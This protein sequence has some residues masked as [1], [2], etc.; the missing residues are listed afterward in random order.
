MKINKENS[1]IPSPN[2]FPVVG[3]GASAG[4]LEAF[5]KLLKAIPENSGMAYVLVQHLDPTHESLLPVLL[6]KVTSLPVLE[7]TDDLKVQPDHIYIIPSNKMLLANDGILKLSPRPEKG[8]NQRNLPIDL[9]FNSLAE[10]HQSYAIGVVLSGTATDGTLGLKAIK[11]QGGLTFAQDE[12][13]AAY[14]SMPHSAMM[15][16]VV[17][18]ILPPEKIPGKLVELT[19][20]IYKIGEQPQT[21]LEKDEAAF[22][23]I[24]SLLRIRKGTDFK[25]GRA[26]CRERV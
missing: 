1:K 20:S 24:L 10:V 22:K 13:S 7:I 19:N 12:A 14:D 2:L 16:G 17:D 23:Q 6:Q 3:I 4:G 15:A 26:S 11:E 25:I 8:K 5:K 9:F 21:A 18:F